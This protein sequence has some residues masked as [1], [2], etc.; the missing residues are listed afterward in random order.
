[1][2]R[3]FSSETVDKAVVYLIDHRLLDDEAFSSHW[4]SS[5]ERRRPKGNR[6]LKQELRQLGVDQNIIEGAL[7][8]IDEETNAGNA[9]RKLASRLVN[10]DCSFEEFRRKVG[11]H[12]QRRGFAYGLVSETVNSLWSELKSD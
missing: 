7:E 9:G 3:R 6:A 4:I 8:G 1:M 11:A 10:Q 5:R 12:L 2:E